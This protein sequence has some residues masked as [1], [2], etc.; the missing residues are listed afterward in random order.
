VNN[1][2]EVEVLLCT[3]NGEKFLKDFLDSLLGQISV[4]VHLRVS[5]DGSTDGTIDILNQYSHKFGSFSLTVGPQKGPSENFFSLIK[6]ANSDFIALADQDDVW[7]PNHLKMSIDRLKQYQNEPAL[8]FCS[9]IEFSS[10]ENVGGTIWPNQ[11]D[12]GSKMALF[13]ENQIRGCTIVMNKPA[14]IRINQSQF[15]IAVMHD[16]WIGLLIHLTGTVVYTNE[17]EIFY[18]LHDNNFVGSQMSLFN[19]FKKFLKSRSDTSNV[20]PMLQLLNIYA[21][22]GP[23]ITDRKIRYVEFAVSKT[24]SRGISKRISLLLTSHRLRIN[25]L[26][27][28]LV[29]IGF[30]IPPMHPNLGLLLYRK[31]RS[32][33]I[34]VKTFVL[35]EIPIII[36][37]FKTVKIRKQDKK[38]DLIKITETFKVSQK[39]AIVAL[40]PRGS[41]QNSV[42][43]LINILKKFDYEVLVVINKSSLSEWESELKSL[44]ISIIKRPNV[45]RDFGAY[46]AGWNFV[47]DTCKLDNI[48]E[49]LFANDSVFYGQNFLEFMKIFEAKNA[50]WTTAFL[51]FEKHTH[52]Q[53]FFQRFSKEILISDE[54]KTFWQDYFPS[55]RRVHAIDKGEV[56]LSQKLIRGGYFPESVV[57]ASTLEKSDGFRHLSFEDK[58]ALLLDDYYKILQLPDEKQVEYF[59]QRF[60]RSFMETN[61]SHT[62][63]LLA[64]KAIGA[65]L[66]LDIVATGRAT[67]E[68]VEIALSQSG[69]DRN[70]VDH[71]RTDFLRMRAALIR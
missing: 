40:Y 23:D 12:L 33:L 62:V 53:S 30:I 55:N 36:N 70:E 24:W 57:T 49:I 39:I 20:S 3:F 26:E 15:P 71:V 37:D 25:L 6:E 11:I 27:E 43:R 67:I 45:G 42:L 9:V 35:I 17:P 7:M 16:W 32:L 54:F 46:K 28:I 5:D 4:V 63:G 13:Y 14:V 59:L 34:K 66:K 51:N 10:E 48:D 56:C 60:R 61:T 29:R 21:N 2:N 69:L 8:S 64:N 68:G 65:P 1:K 44:P 52:A 58:Y 38:F 47:N 41:L 22:Y 19:R 18:R 31:F 50:L